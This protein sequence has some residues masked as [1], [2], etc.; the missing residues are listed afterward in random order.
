MRRAAWSLLA[1]AVLASGCA[2]KTT[3]YYTLAAPGMDAA[4]ASA[5]GGARAAAAAPSIFI[6]LAP[7]AIAD[8]LARPQMLVRPAG[9]RDG[10]AEVEVLEQHR[11]ASSLENELRDA[12]GSGIAAQ[13]GAVDVTRG[14][15]PPGTVAWRLA[16]QV[17]QFDAL[18]NG[19]VDAAFSWTVRRSDDGVQ[20]AACQ[21]SSSEAVGPG[22]DALAEGA[23]R[24]TARAAETMARHVAQQQTSPGAPC[25]AEPGRATAAVPQPA[26]APG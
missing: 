3:R 12:L 26:R 24:L 1:C 22:I 18:E 16:V 10:A 17:R 2:T 11:W 13:L 6:E 25:S 14:T 7:L 23:R 20:S 15:R 9:S 21:W 19:R 4:A 5:Q 8:R